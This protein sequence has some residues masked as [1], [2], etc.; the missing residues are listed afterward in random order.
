MGYIAGIGGANIDMSGRSLSPLIMR[1]SNPGELHQSMGGVC[2]NICE[3]LARLHETVKLV[4]VVGND[5]NGRTLIEGCEKA[6][7]DMSAARML[8][9]ERSSCYIS[10]MDADGDMLLAMSD[11]HIIKQLDER[12]VDGSRDVLNGADL[13]VCD[14]N[15][16]EKAIRRL[17]EICDKPLYMDPVSTAWAREMK[18]CIGFFD[19]VKPN[20]MELETLTDCP[21]DTEEHLQLACDILRGKGVRRVFVSLG[22]DGMFYRGPEGSIRKTSRPFT[23]V[24]NATGAGDAA[25]A[26]IAWATKRGDSAEQIVKTA[27]ACGMIAISS[28]DT[29]SADMSPA[30]IEK[31]I[32]E[33]INDE[34]E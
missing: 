4:T 31:M 27:M 23:N 9:G 32:K 26:G 33:Y 34:A 2:R 19:T 10:I 28:A 20:R 21:C 30:A 14:G 6:G 24:L 7:I 16:S 1:D 3:N 5:A 11:M 22:K 29:I 13:V 15:L 17:T 18:P 8:E 12:L 25:M